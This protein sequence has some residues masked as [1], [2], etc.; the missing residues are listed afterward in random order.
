MRGVRGNAPY[1]FGR[2]DCPQSTAIEGVYRLRGVF[3][4]K[5]IVAVRNSHN[6]I[7]VAG[8]ARVM[9]RHNDLGAR[10]DKRLDLRRIDVRLVRP[11]VRKD[12]L[13]P[14]ADERE[15]RCII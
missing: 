8:A 4:H 5:K 10:R 13:R 6:R 9:D 15:R 1:R 12:D 14:A 7:H 2:A 11:A 3:D